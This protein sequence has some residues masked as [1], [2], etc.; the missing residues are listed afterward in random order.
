M[1][2]ILLILIL[3]TSSVFQA[4]VFDVKDSNLPSE[5]PSGSYIKDIDGDFDKFVGTWVWTNNSGQKVTFKLQ[6][7][8]HYLDAE[9]NY[10]DFMI[11]DYSYS[12]FGRVVVNTINRQ[13]DPNPSL[14]PMYSCCPFDT[15][16]TFTFEDVLMQKDEY[17]AFFEFLPGST[18][19][20]KFTLKNNEGPKGVLVS[21]G[22]SPNV[23][24]PSLTSFPGNITLTKQQ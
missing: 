21:D 6:K 7:V 20:M 23:P 16:I 24:Q 17:S 9:N 1:K 3:L 4:Q 12:V 14:H 13:S 11:G 15:K 2:Y 5:I 10:S 19:Q 22:E 18:T 8:T